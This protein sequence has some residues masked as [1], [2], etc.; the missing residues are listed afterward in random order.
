MHTRRGYGRSPRA[1]RTRPLPHQRRR[2]A[3]VRSTKR[4]ERDTISLSDRIEEVHILFREISSA[5][6]Q[7]EKW[8]NAF[9]NISQAVR[10]KHTLND[11]I[12]AISAIETQDKQEELE[13]VPRDHA[14]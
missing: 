10:D 13:D 6:S 9:Y 4:R 1:Y 7:V 12:S 5:V 11:L 3:P 14:P 2:V 8:M